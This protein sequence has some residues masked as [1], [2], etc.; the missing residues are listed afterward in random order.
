MV[1]EPSGPTFSLK[2]GRRISEMWLQHRPAR[3]P[4]QA[5]GTE[6]SKPFRNV[7]FFCS[8]SSILYGDGGGGTRESQNCTTIFPRRPY[9]ISTAMIFG[10][11]VYVFRCS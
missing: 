7:P 1:W 10:V 2:H 4:C 8:G 6:L 5:D 9:K 11:F 3:I